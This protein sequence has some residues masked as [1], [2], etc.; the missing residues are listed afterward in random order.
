MI[1]HDETDLSLSHKLSVS[2][3][4]ISRLRRG[5]L[6]ASKARAH[7]IEALTGLPWHSFI[8]PASERPKRS[9]RA[10]V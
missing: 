6:G 1:A 10:S 7:E 4:Y 3:A 5:L 8:E 9:E 2:R